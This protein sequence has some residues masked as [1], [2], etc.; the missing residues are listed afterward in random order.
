MMDYSEA[1]NDFRSIKGNYIYRHH[2][3]PR[4]QLYMPKAGTFPRPL[5]FFDVVRTTH[6]TLDVLQESGTDDCW[7]IDGDRKKPR[8][9]ARSSQY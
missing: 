6:A 2:D 1:R 8:P 5:R 9:V 4:V 3:E 7:N